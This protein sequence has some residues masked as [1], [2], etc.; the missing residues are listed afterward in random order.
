MTPI[1]N[2]TRIYVDADA[3]PVKD[4]IYRVASRH[5][6]PVSVVAGNFIRVPQDPMIER[7]AAGSGMDAAGDWIAGRAR[8]G[9]HGITIGFSPAAPWVKRRRR[10]DR[11]ERQ[12]VYGTVDRHDAGGSQSDDRFTFIGRSDRRSQIVRAA[13]PLDV[14]VG[15]RSNHPPHPA[16]A[17]RAIS[18]EIESKSHGA[19]ADPVERHRADLRRHAAIVGRGTVGVISR[20]RVFDRP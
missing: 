14:S 13:R 17:G 12:A 2:T 11:P 5:G 8:K 15:A 20:T 3:C 1:L 18:T 4:E 6:L 19:S 7:V 16:P 9:G 10:G